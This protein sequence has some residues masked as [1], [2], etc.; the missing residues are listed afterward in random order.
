MFPVLNEDEGDP[1]ITAEEISSELLERVKFYVST[2]SCDLVVLLQTVWAI[3]LRQYVE[4]DFLSYVL[5]YTGG[6]KSGVQVCQVSIGPED[7]IERLWKRIGQLDWVHSASF[8]PKK[9]NTG[10]LLSGTVPTSDSTVLL[11]EFR[12][13]QEDEQPVSI[14]ASNRKKVK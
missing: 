2:K 6:T 1:C 12:K 14:G 10:L 3:T 4:T 7:S 13:L 11:D 9:Q 8:D 5:Y